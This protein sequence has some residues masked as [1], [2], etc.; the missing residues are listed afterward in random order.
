MSVVKVGLKFIDKWKT[1]LEK[2][3]CK[4]EEENAPKG[5]IVFYGPSNFTR[6]G[7][8]YGMTPL[9]E[10][11]VGKSGAPCCINRGFGSTCAEH[12]LYYYDRMVKAL[13]PKVLVYS[14]GVGNGTGFGY[15]PEEQWQLAE[16]VM[17]YAKTDFPELKIYLQGINMWRKSGMASW[18][19]D[20]FMRAFAQEMPDCTYL[21]IT[22]Y[23]PL[24]RH[25]IYAPDNV[26]YNKEG[27]DLYA[28]YYRQAL[29]EELDQ[30]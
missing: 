10:A 19:T 26:H 11:V 23:E 1:D 20:Q 9:R 12:H 8:R 14:P 30:F 28:E 5:Q 13:E 16:R 2:Q 29:K 24:H 21:D 17:I 3:V 18:K 27:Y 22:S 6:W 15:T 25:D 7:P 4:Y